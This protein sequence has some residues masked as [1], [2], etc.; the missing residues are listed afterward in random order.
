MHFKVHNMATSGCTY[1]GLFLVH[2]MEYVASTEVHIMQHRSPYYGH[3]CF[4]DVHNMDMSVLW[5][6]ILWTCLCVWMSII[7]T[8]LFYGC[9]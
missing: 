1:Y 6:S 8:S 2:I 7:W 5:M 4:T 3:F 9:P